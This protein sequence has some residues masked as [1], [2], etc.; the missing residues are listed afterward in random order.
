MTEEF[1]WVRLVFVDVFGGA[2]AVMLP[3]SRWSLTVEKGAPF[4]RSALDALQLKP[5]ASS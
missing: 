3:G 4:D 2:H 1:K 5:P